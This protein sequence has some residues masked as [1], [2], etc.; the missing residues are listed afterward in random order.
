LVG[1]GVGV[2]HRP[3]ARLARSFA[4]VL[5]LDVIT[6]TFSSTAAGGLTVVPEIDFR[7]VTSRSLPMP[8]ATTRIP[9]VLAAF[10]SS[11]A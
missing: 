2:E 10:A 11:A 5:K 4:S 7:F 3:A 9:A 8:S 1:V 6:S